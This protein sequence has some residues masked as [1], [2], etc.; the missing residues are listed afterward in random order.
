MVR[1]C[2]VI[3]KRI[4]AILVSR[5][6]STLSTEYLSGRDVVFPYCSLMR[7]SLSIFAFFARIRESILSHAL[8]D[9]PKYLR[10]IIK[11][12]L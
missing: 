9:K 10:P 5:S 6:K 2:L 7:F 11:S 8:G 3:K 12:F 4:L 1:Y